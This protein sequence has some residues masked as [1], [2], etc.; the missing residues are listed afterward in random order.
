MS[1]FNAWVML[2]GLE[3]LPLRVAQQT[4]SAAKI[5]DFLAE[6]KA[7]SRVLYP[8]RADHPQADLARRQMSG[9]GTLVSFSMAG[10]KPAAF[11][12]ANAL[13]VI[14]ISNNL[15]DAKSLITHP[16]T[17]THQRLTPEARASLGIGD[18]LLRLSVGLEDAD[19]LVDDLA[20][21]LWAAARA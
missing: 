9:G 12:L 8:F 10:G 21:G 19:D 11:R 5:A 7:V 2:K 16:A 18:G 14:K 6:E 1:P 20:R 4:A 15:G 13:E 3:T 17:T